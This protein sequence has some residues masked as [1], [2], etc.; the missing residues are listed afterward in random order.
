MSAMF[1]TS[2]ELPLPRPASAH[3]DAQ[4]RTGS[5]PSSSSASRMEATSLRNPYDAD[6]RHRSTRWLSAGS[7]LTSPSSSSIVTSGVLTAASRSRYAARRGDIARV[8]IVA[9]RA[10]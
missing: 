10:K 4:R 7:R 1:T 2:V 5:M 3:T 8:V 9:G 6:C